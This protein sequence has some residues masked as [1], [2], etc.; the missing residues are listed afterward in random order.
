VR[1]GNIRAEIEAE[2][3]AK[4]NGV[5]FAMGG[6]AGGVSL[7]ALNGELYYEYSAILLKRDRIKVGRLPAGD[8]TIALEMRTPMERAAPASLK[9]WINGKEAATGTVQR[10]VPAVFTASE[11]FDVGMDTSSPVAN[12]YF[13][14]APFKFEGTLK[15]L[16]FKNLGGENPEFM[17]LPDDD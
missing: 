8:V 14:K 6:Y 2:V 5:I 3:P 12:D 9:F 17:P 16:Y 1:N 15:R 10:T 7:Y 13:D 4:V 11:T